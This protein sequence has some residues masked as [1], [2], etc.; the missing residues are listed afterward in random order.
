MSLTLLNQ[1]PQYFNN[2][3]NNNNDNNF[4]NGQAPDCNPIRNCQAAR[5]LINLIS[6]E[7]S[8]AWGQSYKGELT[9]LWHSILIPQG[10]FFPFPQIVLTLWEQEGNPM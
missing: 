8:Q 7:V 6:T 1:I 2:N 5:A 4:F 10:I 3:A 9:N